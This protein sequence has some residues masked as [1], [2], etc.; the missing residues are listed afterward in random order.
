MSM[1]TFARISGGVVLELLQTSADVTGLFHPSIH[2]VDV[3]GTAVQV[4]WVESGTTFAPPPAALAPPAEIAP[5]IAELQ[6]ELSK[7]S[8]RIAAFAKSHGG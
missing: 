3:T 4:G 2:W 5:T 1:K 7:L 6:A 8:T